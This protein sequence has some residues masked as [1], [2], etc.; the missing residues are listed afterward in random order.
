MTQLLIT[1]AILGIVGYFLFKRRKA[2]APVAPES[3]VNYA[4]LLDAEV[5]FYQKLDSA[6]KSRFLNRPGSD[7]DCFKCCHSDIWFS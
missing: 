1:L 2:Q 3:T 7:T 4:K 5:A 6:G